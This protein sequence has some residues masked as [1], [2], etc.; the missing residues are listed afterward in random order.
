MTVR[1]AAP[2]V[3]GDAVFSNDTL[4]AGVAVTVTV[5][6]ADD[7]TGPTGGVPDATAVSTIEPASMSA[8]V[9]S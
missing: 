1:P 2:T 4:G 6:G 8:C 3:V 5:E 7:T 9:T